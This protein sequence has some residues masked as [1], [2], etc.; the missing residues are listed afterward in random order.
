[1]LVT[2]RG[3]PAELVM[4]AALVALAPLDTLLAS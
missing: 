1:V 3:V 2:A 4:L